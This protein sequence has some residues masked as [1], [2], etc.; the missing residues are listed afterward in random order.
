[1]KILL[2]FAVIVGV[3][4]GGCYPRPVESTSPEVYVG[5]YNGHM[6]EVIETSQSRSIMLE[7][8]GSTS[9]VDGSGTVYE[10]DWRPESLHFHGAP[11]CEAEDFV[12]VRIESLLVSDID[13]GP[14]C[15]GELTF[16]QVWE[17]AKNLEEART[18]LRNDTDSLP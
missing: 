13:W 11:F 17:T 4:L 10:E 1:M 15:K 3:S 8:G 2:S 14:T 5:L 12:T 18:A 6:V 16:D 9:W 7:N